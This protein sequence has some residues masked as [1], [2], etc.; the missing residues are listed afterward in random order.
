MISFYKPIYG[1]YGFGV[2][3]PIAYGFMCF[4]TGEELERQHEEMLYI[5]PLKNLIVAIGVI[6][7][8]IE[9]SKF[10]MIYLILL[11]RHPVLEI[12][13]DNWMVSNI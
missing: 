2:T 10:W 6:F 4:I 9:L 3:K 8:S 13:K 5:L 1:F 11:L 12:S 7:I